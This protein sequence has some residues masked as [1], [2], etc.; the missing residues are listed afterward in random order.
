MA[1]N[2]DKIITIGRLSTFYDELKKVFAILSSDNTFSGKNTHTGLETF[3]YGDKF[4]RLYGNQIKVG[5]YGANGAVEDFTY[6]FQDKSGTLAFTNDITNALSS[7]ATKSELDNKQDTIADLATIRSNA[8]N[9]NQRSTNNATSIGTIA[10]LPNKEKSLVDA[11][12]VLNTSVSTAKTTA[13]KANT[14]ADQ[15]AT[16]IASLNTTISEIKKTADEANTNASNAGQAIT[17]VQ[18][19]L[20]QNYYTKEQ[21]DALH[22]TM[23]KNATVQM[24]ALPETGEEGTIY[25][26]GKKGAKFYERYVWED[27]AW[28]HLGNTQ[29]DLN[30][31]AKTDVANTFTKGQ[32]FND[33]I[34]GNSTLNITNTETNRTAIYTST[35][36]NTSATTILS[37]PTGKTGTFALTSDI[38]SITGYVKSDGKGTLAKGDFKAV[39]DDTNYTTFGNNSIKLVIASKE[40]DFALPSASGTLA[41]K[42]YIDSKVSGSIVYA[43]DDDVKS[44]FTTQ[45]A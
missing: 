9:A 28:V 2:E 42:E 44:L 4:I 27:E 40:Y 8:A 23:K 34:Y 21:V 11:I 24:D 3:R 33:I 7:Y 17:N 26:I 5:S 43:S 16:D 45:G 22:A 25:L 19:S 12:V 18:N 13:D 36:V 10:N 15:N 38:P 1:T 14:K 31:Y 39:S 41:T 37:Y 6:T 30:G 35:G 32:T 29:I 20:T